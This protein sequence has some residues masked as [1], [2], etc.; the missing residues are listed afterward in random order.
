MDLRV[1]IL[2]HNYCDFQP[3][4]S[5]HNAFSGSVLATG[6]VASGLPQKSTAEPP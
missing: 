1:L 3:H 4:F 2:L 6:I 5:S